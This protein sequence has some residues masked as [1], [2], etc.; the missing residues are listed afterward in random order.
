[1]LGPLLFL[2]M[3]NENNFL[4]T[5]IYNYVDDITDALTHKPGR[6]NILLHEALPQ[7][8][9]W[10]LPNKML[11][12]TKKCTEIKFKVNNFADGDSALKIGNEHLTGTSEVNRKVVR[13]YPQKMISK[14]E[15]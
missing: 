8:S 9:E 5:N 7:V 13:K 2:L 10:V 15:K 11:V 4:H 1:M 6:G 3:L 12:N 14:C